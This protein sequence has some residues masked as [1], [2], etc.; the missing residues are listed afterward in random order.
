MQTFHMVVTVDKIYK[1]RLNRVSN[2]ETAGMNK[3]Q[4]PFML[5]SK[6][7]FTINR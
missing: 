7:P 5:L 2:I 6:A 3:R 4:G 1:F